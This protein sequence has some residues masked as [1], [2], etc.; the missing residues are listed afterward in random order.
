VSQKRL[1]KLFRK[2]LDSPL[3][4][5]GFCEYEGINDRTFRRKVR[6]YWQEEV[7]PRKFSISNQI[8]VIDAKRLRRDCCLFVMRT[9]E[10]VITWGY[11]QVES[12]GN[13]Y[14]F[15]SSVYGQPLAVVCD[16][17]KGILK[18]IRELYPRT[19]IQ[20]CHFH[21]KAR[22]RQLLTLN[23]KTKAGVEFKNIVDSIT[24]VKDKNDLNKWLKNY[25]NWTITYDEYLK[26]KT[27]FPIDPLYPYKGYRKGKRPWFYTHRNLR[28]AR[29]QIKKSLP[30]LFIYLKYP[31]VPSTSNLLEGGINS[32]LE[33]I[34][35]RHRGL[36]LQKQKILIANYLA[37]RQ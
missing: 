8:I 18:A 29:H 1:K 36:T 15:L 31:D 23:P 13:W 2:R 34:I 9:P 4:L 25:S 35:N 22:N 6:E 11:Y 16:G 33:D 24:R 28:S 21:I 30:N 7:I 3:T 19:Y 20:R 37:K 14:Q 27:Y 17:Q 12:Y 10:R 5:K 26:E 32:P